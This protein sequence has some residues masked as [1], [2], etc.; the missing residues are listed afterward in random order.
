MAKSADERE[1]DKRIMKLFRGRCVGNTSHPATVVH[2][3]IPRARSKQAITMPQNR[4]PLC[5]YCHEMTHHG[6]YTIEKETMLRLKAEK[7]LIML[8]ESLEDW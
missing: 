2:E 1:S 6:G 5:R 7:R 4:V 8:G 3:L